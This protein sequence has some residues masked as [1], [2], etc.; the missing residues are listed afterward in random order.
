MLVVAATDHIRV[1]PPAERRPPPRRLATAA[2]QASSR[3]DRPSPSAAERTHPLGAGLHPGFS[4]AWH[5]PPP[6]DLPPP[7]PAS[8]EPDP[9]GVMTSRGGRRQGGEGGSRPALA[10]LP[11][12]EKRSLPPAI[13]VSGRAFR[14]SEEPPAALL[15]AT[16]C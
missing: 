15:G 7:D 16:A 5:Y 4:P 6:R 3:S 13:I 9:N 8:E 2:G 14:H 12:D 1:D 10:A 11:L